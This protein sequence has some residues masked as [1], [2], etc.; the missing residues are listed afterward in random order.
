MCVRLIKQRLIVAVE[1]RGEGL[2][3][4]EATARCTRLLGCR[5]TC[6]EMPNLENL[7]VRAPHD[8]GAHTRLASVQRVKAR[9]ACCVISK[10][11][12]KLL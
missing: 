3:R 4:V 8:S 1:E 9:A 10:Y 7:S 5:G 2:A 6:Q 12:P 11:V